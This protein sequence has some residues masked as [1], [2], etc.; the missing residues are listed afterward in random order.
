MGMGI[1][2]KRDIIR[3]MR[4]RWE[5]QYHSYKPD[6]EL[7]ILS[8]DVNGKLECPSGITVRRVRAALATLDLETCSAEDINTIIGNDSWTS[9]KCDE[10]EQDCEVL[11]ELSSYGEHFYICAKC[12]EESLKMLKKE[13]K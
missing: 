10:C 6:F 13:A 2:R 5:K 9:N 11:L 3:N 1:I 12:L 4:K 7:G 8:L